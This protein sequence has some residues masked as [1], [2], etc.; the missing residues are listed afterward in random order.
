MHRKRHHCGGK[1]TYRNRD[2]PLGSAKLNTGGVSAC[3][4]IQ[5]I[6]THVRVCTDAIL[7]SK[8]GAN[9]LQIAFACCGE[10][11]GC[12]HP[13]PVHWSRPSTE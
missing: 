5:N 2:T 12:E 7:F 10:Q 11:P 9:R 8:A 3:M 6:H 4:Y 1:K 13:A